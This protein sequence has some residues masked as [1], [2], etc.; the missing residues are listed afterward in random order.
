MRWI[1]SRVD[2]PS[3]RELRGRFSIGRCDN[4]HLLMLFKQFTKP[5][6]L[7]ALIAALYPVLMLFLVLLTASIARLYL[8]HW[9]SYNNPD[10]GTIA[11]GLPH[12][13]IQLCFIP[14]PLS[15]FLALAFAFPGPASSKAA[16]VWPILIVMILS[17]VAAF[18]YAETDPGGVLD[19][20]LNWF[21]D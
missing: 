5:L 20:F 8:G 16:R 18:V 11:W 7:L 14:L 17:W 2:I 4:D 19:M 6:P 21:A 12:L 13:V 9:P 3:C 15:P 1:C 10:P